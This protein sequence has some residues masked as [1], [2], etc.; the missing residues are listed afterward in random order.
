MTNKRRI[1][2]TT[3]GM[4]AAIALVLTQTAGSNRQYKLGGSFIGCN[5][6][7]DVWN[8]QQIPMEPSARVAAIRVNFVTYG[9][10]LTELLT[11]FGADSLTD[12]VG[13]AEM[14]S[15]DTAKWTFTGYAQAQGH[16]PVIQAIFVVGG[17]LKFSGPDDFVV[18]Y[19]TSVFPAMADAN[20]DGYPDQGEVPTL[21]IP[22]LDHARRVPLP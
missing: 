21:S 16:P 11:A 12:F 15:R 22:R 13:E 18:E 3:L 10:R 5:D 19:T 17:T 2:L 20:L 1:I 7:G 14:I 6:R 8:C 9:A 4:A